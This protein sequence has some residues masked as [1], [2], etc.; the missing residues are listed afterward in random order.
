MDQ[1]LDGFNANNVQQWAQNQTQRA[2]AFSHDLFHDNVVFDTETK[3]L[4]VFFI[5][6]M[7]SW[8]L[9]VVRAVGVCTISG[10]TSKLYW[11]CEGQTREGHRFPIWG[12]FKRTVTYH[13]GSM[14]FG[15]AVLRLATVFICALGYLSEQIKL[16]FADG[17]TQTIAKVVRCCLRCI[18]CCLQRFVKYLT[19]SSYVIIA[20][21][22]GSFC[23]ATRNAF[24]LMSS[25]TRLLAMNNFATNVLTTIITLTV[26]LVCST[27]T[28][29]VLEYSTEFPNWFFSYY[30]MTAVHD[31]ENPTL[32][33]LVTFI[34]SYVVSEAFV[35]VLQSTIEAVFL[36]YCADVKLN[37]QEG[38]LA[39]NMLA[40]EEIKQADRAVQEEEA[41][42]QVAR[43]EAMRKARAADKNRRRG[44][45]TVQ[46]SDPDDVAEELDATWMQTG[47]NGDPMKRA[48]D[49]PSTK[50][51]T[52]HIPPLDAPTTDAMATV[53][54][55]VNGKG[56]RSKIVL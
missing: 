8:T 11:Y 50:G 24:V 53:D 22:G 52:M 21:Q 16:K 33:M 43:A 55:N 38:Q 23:A 13:F 39:R 25:Q 7:V 36:C 5:S 31:V 10:A 48:F 15:A 6:C 30:G 35:D 42:T 14:I 32:P 49:A 17:T 2:V 44:N 20:M 47:G 28:F 41:K 4:A 1:G 27:I 45:I 26:A 46:P 19:A 34:F 51:T 54:A 37:K 56:R 18:I 9:E 12:A 29:L 3:V 40:L